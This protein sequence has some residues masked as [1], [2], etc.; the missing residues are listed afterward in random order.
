[1]MFSTQMKRKSEATYGNQR[2]SAFA[3]DARLGDLLLDELVDRLAGRLPA[4]GAQREPEAHEPDAEED[5]EEPAQPEVD[6]RL[7]D[8][9]VERADLDRDPRVEDEL[10][11]RVEVPG[12]GEE[13][14]H[15][16]ASPEKYRARLAPSSM[17]YAAA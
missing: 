10:V 7:V 17:L 2:C 1:M 8:R 16:F 11:L 3:G 6:D 12:G 5:R 9:E 15:P 4:V 14:V 13:Q